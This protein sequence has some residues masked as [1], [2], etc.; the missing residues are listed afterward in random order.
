MDP[1]QPHQISSDGQLPKD[2]FLVKPLGTAV[3][4]TKKQAH[5]NIHTALAG[6]KT[7]ALGVNLMKPKQSKRV[8]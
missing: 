1:H 4:F 6:K 7:R 2:S 3:G 5:P 8:T